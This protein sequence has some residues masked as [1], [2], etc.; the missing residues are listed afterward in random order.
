LTVVE[1]VIRQHR[2][3]FSVDGGQWTVD[4]AL[5][6]ERMGCAA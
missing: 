5:L 4:E 6:R 3:R 2:V 1:A